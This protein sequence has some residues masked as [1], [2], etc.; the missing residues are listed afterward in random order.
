L[1]NLDLL[2]ANIREMS[3]LSAAAGVKLRPH[4]KVHESAFIAKMQIEAGAVGIEVGTLEQAEAMAEEGLTNII[5]AHPIYGELKLATLKRLLRRS[6]VTLALVVDMVEQAACISQTAQEVR[7]EVPVLV[8]INIGGNRFG[9]LPGEPV[10]NFVK[11]LSRLSGIRFAGIYAHE[12]GA[13]PTQEGVDKNAFEA[14]SIMEQTATILKKEG[15]TVDH[16]SVGASSTFRSTCR[17]IIEGQFS[18]ITE[19]HPG[20]CI[21]GDMNYARSFAM[22]E[23]RCALTVLTTVT[24]AHA[25][26]A[27]IDCGAK[28]FGADLTGLREA[29]GFGTIRRHPDLFLRRMSNETSIVSYGDSEKRLSL[30]Q[31]LEIVPNNALVVVNIHNDMY[32]VRNGVVERVIPITGRGRGN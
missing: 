14:A 27:V 23:S 19:I 1:L 12:M 13:E 25:D 9:I 8:K 3:Q 15:I 6:G 24:S 18:E 16:V 26:R 29:P 2:E 17:F 10:V 20:G 5:I 7:R 21:V 30:G 31:R 22:P 4:I 28:T 32:G 11:E